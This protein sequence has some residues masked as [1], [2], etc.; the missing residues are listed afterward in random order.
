MET[1]QPKTKRGIVYI[2]QWGSNRH[3]ANV[4]FACLVNSKSDGA[5]N[6]FSRG[7]INKM[8][9]DESQNLRSFVVGYGFN[10]PTQ[11]HHR[12]SSCPDRPATCG[13]NEFNLNRP[14]PQVLNGALVGG[15]N[16]QN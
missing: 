4:A 7:Q 2:Q 11:P 9:G 13:W 15:V 6:K 1:T 8:L 16:S 3:A 14:N 12:P 10:P 5:F